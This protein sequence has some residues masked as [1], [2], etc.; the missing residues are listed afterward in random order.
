M[1]IIAPAVAKID[2]SYTVPEKIMPY[3][4]ASGAFNLLASGAPL[5]RLGEA[6]LAVYI[7]RLDIRTKVAAGQAPFNELPGVGIVLS[8]ISTPTYLFRVRAEYDL[9]DT[10]TAA[11]RGIAIDQAHRLGMRQAHFQLLRN[12]LL[13]GMNPANGEG[14]INANGAVSIAL[15]PDQ[16]GNQ[17]VVTYDNGAMAFFILGVITALLTRT[18]QLG[19]PR[20]FVIC[21]PQR[22]LGAF[23]LANIVQL[24]QYQRPGAGSQT[25]AGVVKD[26][27]ESFGHKLTWV[28]DDTLIGKGSGGVDAVIITMPEVENPTADASYNTNVFADLEPGLKACTM[29]LTDVAAPQEITA[30]LPAGAVDIVSEMRA[31]SGWAVR[32]ECVTVLSMQY[33]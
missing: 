23:E 22:T 4:Q 14:L 27:L 12:A 24:V 9:H 28:Y 3:T 18:N 33:Q 2:P 32:G 25:T 21:G 17:T 10:A 26:V 11:R 6:D 31:S 1:A 29:Q 30:P 20:E 5:V 15:P 7:D 19:I 16:N 8:Q 13:F